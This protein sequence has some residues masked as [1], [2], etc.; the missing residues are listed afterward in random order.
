MALPM[1][2]E[3]SDP[4]DDRAMG[5]SGVIMR[6]FRPKCGCI[7]ALGS[8]FRRSTHVESGTLRFGSPS[9]KGS[10]YLECERQHQQKDAGKDKCQ[11]QFSRKIEKSKHCRRNKSVH[12]QKN[13]ETIALS[14]STI[15]LN[16]WPGLLH[17]SPTPSHW[18]V[19][20]T[21]RQFVR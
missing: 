3:H 5:D 8:G 7:C 16:A 6:E 10:L 20:N 9:Q 15:P 21:E 12:D 1:F 14:E 11:Q 19:E 2:C 18:Q 13:F 17:V 4:I